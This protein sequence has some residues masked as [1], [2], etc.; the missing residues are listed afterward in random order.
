MQIPYS[1][2]NHTHYSHDSK[3]T[4]RELAQAALDAGLTE[5]GIADHFDVHPLLPPGR[6]VGGVLDAPGR[7]RRQGPILKSRH[8]GR[9]TASLSF[10]AE[11][12][13]GAV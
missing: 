4:I 10:G 5:L 7:V 2:H 12:D 13:T 3:T 9:R 11:W 1:Y 6:M 8:R